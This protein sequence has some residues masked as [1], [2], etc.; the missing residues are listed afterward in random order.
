ML[1]MMMSRAFQRHDV[2]FY[3]R[4]GLRHGEF[5]LP[6][7]QGEVQVLELEWNCDST[8]LAL[9]IASLD[10]S[11]PWS[12]LQLWTCTNYHWYLKQQYDFGAAE[13][14]GVIVDFRWDLEDA[15]RVVVAS[16]EGVIHDYQVGLAVD[17]TRGW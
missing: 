9:W 12:C 14:N 7:A 17:R 3:E 1:V 5:T 13:K 16:S 15:R 6:F 2:I 11:Q 8:V 10:Q 4:N